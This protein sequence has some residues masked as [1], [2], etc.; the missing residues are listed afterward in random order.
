VLAANIPN[1]RAFPTA[2]MDYPDDVTVKGPINSISPQGDRSCDDGLAIIKVDAN[3]TPGLACEDLDHKTPC[4]DFDPLGWTYELGSV[5]KDAGPLMGRL[6]LNDSAS[7]IVFSCDVTTALPAVVPFDSSWLL[8]GTHSTSF[9]G[10]SKAGATAKPPVPA[11]QPIVTSSPEPPKPP[12]PAP[13]PPPPPSARPQP[14]PTP[15]AQT[16]GGNRPPSSPPAASPPSANKPPT[17]Q[18]GNDDEPS[19]PSGGAKAPPPKG[20]PGAFPDGSKDPNDRGGEPSSSGPDDSDPVDSVP[21]SGKPSSAPTVDGSRSPTPTVGI[22]SR[23]D[24]LGV[25]VT[26]PAMTLAL[27][28]VIPYLI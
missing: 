1:Q 10:G 6:D 11:P 8:V 25:V 7:V 20:A 2:I 17:V 9:A 21:S 3:P 18:P 14:P 5:P 26:V 16:A 19:T 22:V 15:P 23:A 27:A 28:L 12:K 13:P 24:K 4:L